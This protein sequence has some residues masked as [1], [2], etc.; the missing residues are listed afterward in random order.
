MDERFDKVINKMDE[1]TEKAVELQKHVSSLF[2]EIKKTQDDIDGRVDEVNLELEKTLNNFEKKSEKVFNDIKSEFDEQKS[3]AVVATNNASDKLASLQKEYEEKVKDLIG[4]I[5][6][7]SEEILKIY[8][9]L[10]NIKKI[11]Q[12]AVK[13]FGEISDNQKELIADF[14]EKTIKLISES[15][16]G[17]VIKVVE[18]FQ[19]RIAKL[20]KH[21]HMHTFGGNKI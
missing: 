6:G 8:D 20:E 5:D 7:K 17:N 14:K 21:A 12:E 3:G 4:S 10:E 19:S 15:D 11:Q 18:S 9:E 2:Y 1:Q 13:T 16:I